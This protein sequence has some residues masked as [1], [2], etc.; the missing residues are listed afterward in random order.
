MFNSCSHEHQSFPNVDVVEQILDP[1]QVLLPNPSTKQGPAQ[2]SLLC[3]LCGKRFV[4][5]KSPLVQIKQYFPLR[6]FSYISSGHCEQSSGKK[7]FP[8]Q[9]HPVS[10]TFGNQQYCWFNVTAENEKV[11]VPKTREKKSKHLGLIGGAC[12]NKSTSYT[13]FLVRLKERHILNGTIWNW[14]NFGISDMSF[15]R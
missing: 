5:E 2:W 6:N 15:G 4:R 8:G 7:G 12:E 11:F 1:H 14:I 10:Q 9:K 13:Q 3:C